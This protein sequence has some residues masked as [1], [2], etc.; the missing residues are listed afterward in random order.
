MIGNVRTLGFLA[1]FFVAYAFGAF[2]LSERVPYVHAVLM[3]YSNRW[4]SS[5]VVLTAFG[6]YLALRHQ[7]MEISG[8]R[9]RLLARIWYAS[10]VAYTLALVWWVFIYTTGGI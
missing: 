1:A 2:W 8:P 4:V 7:H 9:R 10:L 3:P 6:G 5:L